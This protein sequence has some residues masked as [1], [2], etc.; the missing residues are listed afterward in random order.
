VPSENKA[1]A[2]LFDFLVMSGKT[3]DQFQPLTQVQRAKEYAK[4]LVSPFNLVSAAISAGI[5]QWQ[6]VPNAWGQGAEGF[7]HRFGNYVARQEITRTLLWGGEAALHEDNRYFQSGKHGVWARTKYALVS[8][9]VARHDNGKQYV[10]FSRLGSNAGGA[11][12]SRTWQ[13]SSNNS[14]GDGAMS[15]GISMGTNAGLNVLREFL[16]GILHKLHHGQ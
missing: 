10:S 5:T 6:D 8:S 14:A 1:E 15:F 2:S 16:P 9:V 3:Q 13:P 12:L 7:G 4:G 11:F